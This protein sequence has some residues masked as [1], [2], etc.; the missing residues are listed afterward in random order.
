MVQSE[1][2]ASIGQLAA[3]VAH[4]INNPVGYVTSNL[5]TVR[6]Y[7]EAMRTALQLYERLAAS[8]DDRTLRTA[9]ERLR[10]SE[11]LDFILGDLDGLVGEC[12]EGV[13]RVTDIV[14]SL[15]SFARQEGD[16]MSFHDL[17]A[18]VEAMVRMCWNE[19]KYKCT[20]EREYGSLPTIRCH[21]GRI[22]QVV[23]NVLI[24]AAQAIPD[25]GGTI[26][27]GTALEDDMAVVTIS[28]TGCG[29]DAAT[30]EQIFDP[31]FTTK[32]VGKGTGLGLSISHGIVQEH[33]GRIEVVSEAGRGT[34]FRIL[35][36]VE[37]AAADAA[38]DE[39]ETVD[40]I[41]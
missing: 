9:I 4:E 7:I 23:M 32:G 11:D 15:K 1:K 6:E 26:T 30:R 37:T 2:L 10:E 5:V 40:V 22:S 38:E 41:G 20:V 16:G 31:F 3:G 25:S 34:T 18:M 17:N 27:V 14:Q 19:L 13:S 24:N 39:P 12:L 21:E 8:P 33:G 28:D 29:M 36:P 35:L